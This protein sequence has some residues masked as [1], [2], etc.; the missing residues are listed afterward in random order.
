MLIQLKSFKYRLYPTNKQQELLSKTFG[1]VRY[2][3]NQ[4]VAT[5]NTYSKDTKPEY[6][7]STEIRKSLEWMKEVSAA[8]LQQ[9]ENDFKEFL[10]GYFS[11]SRKNKLSGPNF[12]N[13][14]SKQ[15][16]RLPNQKFSMDFKTS[17]IKLEKI[18]KIKFVVDREIPCN[19][20]YLSVTVSRDTVG[21]YYAVVLVELEI[22]QYKPT[23]N[24]IGIDVGIKEFYSTSDGTLVD[25][26]KY[27]HKSQMKLRVAQQHLSRK[28]KGSARYKKCKLKVAKI[29]KKITN[30]RNWFLH[31]YSNELIKNYDFI[32]IENLNIDN[33]KQNH[34]LAKSISDT[35]WATFIN[36]LIYKA[37]WYGKQ[38]QKVDRFFASSKICSECG[39]KKEDLDLSER[40]YICTNCGTSNHRDINAARNILKEALRVSNAIRTQ[41]DNKTTL[42]A[43]FD[44]VYRFQ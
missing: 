8:A 38:V 41:R 44:E 34:I 13:K 5:F 31:Q 29:H 25:N 30:Q 1:C 32:G 21:H 7:S 23:G 15:S 24:A 19:S 17:K 40:E 35:S 42:V 12:K 26:P 2:I 18:G 22:E 33:M 14:N 20:R 28:R 11:K 9:K 43:N 6:R 16:F 36:M 4:N 27:F 10:K 39:N 3:W 37:K